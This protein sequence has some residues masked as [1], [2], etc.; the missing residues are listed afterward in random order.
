MYISLLYRV[1][2]FSFTMKITMAIVKQ[3][4]EFCMHKNLY[5]NHSDF[6]FT[7][8]SHEINSSQGH[9]LIALTVHLRVSVGNYCSLMA[10]TDLLKM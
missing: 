6:I 10:R 2:T 3:A 9:S 8:G 7:L 4:S 1:Y 5:R